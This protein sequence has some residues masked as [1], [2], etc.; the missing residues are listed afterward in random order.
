MMGY[1]TTSVSHGATTTEIINSGWMEKSSGVAL[2]LAREAR[3]STE[4]S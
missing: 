4:V 1:F 3:L 2:A